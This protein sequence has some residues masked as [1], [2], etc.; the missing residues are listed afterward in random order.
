MKISFAIMCVTLLALAIPI[1][2][3]A[4]A[5]T[6]TIQVNA[7][8]PVQDNQ[9]GEGI[10]TGADV[11]NH[12]SGDFA[13]D[14]AGGSPNPEVSYDPNTDDL[15]IETGFGG[16]TAEPDVFTFSS[17]SS[18]PDPVTFTFALD[19]ASFVNDVVLPPDGGEDTLSV[20]A[21]G[22]V[23]ATGAGATGMDLTWA[24]LTITGEITSE[25]NQG[26]WI[27]FNGDIN[28]LLTATG[29][30]VDLPALSEASD[31]ALLLLMGFGLCLP[32]WHRMGRIGPIKNAA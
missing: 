20:I 14:L 31:T 6:G 13:A 21:G 24:T 2:A 5:I 11:Q 23:E 32:G 30:P 12:N 25:P 9:Y 29:D 17:Y 10:W 3:R 18:N 15:T 19:P 28:A 1:S 7:A 26:G 8:T 22:V 27:Y 4:D 16:S